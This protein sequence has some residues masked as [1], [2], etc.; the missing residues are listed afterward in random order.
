MSV[1]VKDMD[2]PTGCLSCDFCN[3]FVDEPYCRRLMKRAPKAT[4]LEDCPLAPAADVREE[5]NIFKFYYVRSIDE[6]WI[7]QRVGN[8]YYAEYNKGQWVWTHSR[9]LPWG[10]HVT[11]PDTLWKEH[12]YPS[13][14]E[15]LPV[16]EWRTG[17]IKRHA[18][19]GLT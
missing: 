3:P 16:S 15:E 1:F 8:F 10:E 18:T 5:E 11:S 17:F 7:G 19:A 4:R 9:Y 14:P 12:T 2:M 6:Y 13:E